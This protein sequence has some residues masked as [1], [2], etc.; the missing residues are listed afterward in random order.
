MSSAARRSC[1]HASAKI[2]LD[3]YGLVV[4]VTEAVDRFRNGELDA[5]DVDEVLFQYSRAAKELGRF[6]NMGDVELTARQVHGGPPIDGIQGSVPL[7]VW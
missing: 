3:T 6:C 4:H 1:K 7:N 5:L 2:T